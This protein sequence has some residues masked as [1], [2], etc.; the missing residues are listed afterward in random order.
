MSSLLE[1]LDNPIEAGVEFRSLPI[2]EL[3][4]EI[5]A[6]KKGTDGRIKVEGY[7]STF[8]YEDS[9]R[10]VLVKGAFKNS[11][12]TRFKENDLIRFLWQHNARL[13][14]FGIPIE[15]A[16]DSK[17]LWTVAEVIE[18]PTAVNEWLPQIRQKGV[19]GLSIGFMVKDYDIEYE[20]DDDWWGTRYINDVELIEWSAVTFPANEESWIEGVKSRQLMRARTVAKAAGEMGLARDLDVPPNAVGLDAVTAVAE[21]LA[22]A[23]KA[24]TGTDVPEVRPGAPGPGERR[25]RPREVSAHRE[26]PPLTPEALRRDMGLEP[27]REPEPDVAEQAFEELRSFVQERQS[28]DD[29]L[30]ELMAEIRS[31]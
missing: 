24:L 31:R 23:Y 1:L 7:A 20:S 8:G 9:Y 13:G 3:D 22:A 16:E 25:S 6:K 17:G 5:K 28:E 14:A 26:S 2:A 18:T 29:A 10:D 15:M 11:I 4:F 27:E 21:Q 12:K 19:Q 30:A